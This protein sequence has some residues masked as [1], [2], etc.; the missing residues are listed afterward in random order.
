M[1]AIALFSGGK[2]STY[3]LYIAMQ[4]GFEVERL[5]TIFPENDESYMYHIPAIERTKIQSE[6]IGIEQ[7]V[8]RIGDDIEE[9][10]DVISN[11]DVD[12]LISGAIAS[13]Y[14]KTRIEEI[15]TDLNML[16][17]APLWGKRQ[18]I[19]L[20]DMLL[21]GFEIIIV[22]VSA[23]GLDSSDLGEKLD[24]DMLNKLKKLESEYRINLS[25]EGGEYETFVLD[26]PIFRKRI[27][28]NKFSKSWDGMRGVIE[29]EDMALKEKSSVR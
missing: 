22:G 20:K 4:Q 12:S 25:G 10:K 17:Y 29:I 18:D 26:S 14:Q 7:D 3:S 19:V 5:I 2:D 15:C 1:R 21:A 28:I 11:Y 6:L 27:S 24:W 9:L 16:S 13:N 23:Y 8:Y